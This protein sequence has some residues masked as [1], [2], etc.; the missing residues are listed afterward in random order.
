MA[1]KDVRKV[2]RCKLTFTKNG[3]IPSAIDYQKYIREDDL[4][5]GLEMLFSCL[6]DYYE[7]LDQ[8]DVAK[9]LL[10]IEKTKKDNFELY[11]IDKKQRS[12]LESPSSISSNEGRSRRDSDFN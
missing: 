2:D 4:K 8:N 9:V 5:R 1:G 6:R 3:I 7:R 11:N 12:G 10:E